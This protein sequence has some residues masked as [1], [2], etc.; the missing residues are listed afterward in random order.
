MKKL[1]AVFTGIFLLIIALP[2]LFMDRKSAVSEKENR[3]LAAFPRVITSDG[4]IDSENIA[5]FPRM[6]DSYI[7]DRFGFRN[8]FT[9]LA[10]AV[11]TTK[12]INGYVVTGKNDWLFYSRSD[13]GNNIADFFKLNLLTKTEISRFIENIDRRRRWCEDN[14][15]KFIFLIAPNKHNVYPEYYPFARPEGITR[16]EQIMAAL[17]DTLK[18]TVIYPLDSLLQHKG[19]QNP[20]YFETGTH[21]NMAGAYLVYE[22]LLDRIK[23]LF[24]Q[25]SFPAIDFV[26]EISYDDSDSIAFMSGFSSYGKTTAP[27]MRP[28]EGWERYYRY[29]KNEDRNSIIIENTDTAL[30]RAVIFR[31]SFFMALEPFTSTLFSSAEYHWRWFT[32]QDKQ[33]IL[34]NKPDIIIWDVVERATAGIRH[35]PW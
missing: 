10:A 33:T 27:V 11:N 30:P 15:I 2:F 8:T 13:D 31:D 16:T 20:L 3:T 6:A 22:L 1:N 26:T 12:I 25:T 34:Q 17:P 7:N 21:W 19:G 28:V 32:E 14:G 4:R 29:T 9:T 5:K 24:P 35:L 23:Q 18:D